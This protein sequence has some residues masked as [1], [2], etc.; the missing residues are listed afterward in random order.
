MCAVTVTW[1][2]NLC[3]LEQC[4]IRAAGAVSVCCVASIPPQEPIS[5]GEERMLPDGGRVLSVDSHPGLLGPVFPCSF[6]EGLCV[7]CAL[8]L[9]HSI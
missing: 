3:D 5:P 6:Q 2:R 9:D 7:L 1:G 4:V 8:H